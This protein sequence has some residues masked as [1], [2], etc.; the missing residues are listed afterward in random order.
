M[1]MQNGDY[2]VLWWAMIFLK[3]I[4]PFTTL[5]FPFTR[6][7]PQATVAVAACIITGTLFERFNWIAGIDGKG[8]F[9]VLWAIVVGGI[10]M[11]IGYMLVGKA[12]QR[13]NLIKG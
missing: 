10:V 5:A 9:P 2:S 11:S 6:H 7:T 8:T 4:I 3:F 12:L 1:A 13:R